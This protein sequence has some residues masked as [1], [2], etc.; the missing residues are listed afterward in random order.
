MTM[1]KEF[2]AEARGLNWG[3]LLLSWI[4]GLGNSVGCGPVALMFIIPGIGPIVGLIKGNEWAWRG[5]Q[6]ASVEAFKATQK[7]WAMAG[8]VVLVVGVLLGCLAGI[9]PVLMSGGGN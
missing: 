1:Q 6:W 8:V 2:P 9:L 4:W 5:K 3:A 7:K